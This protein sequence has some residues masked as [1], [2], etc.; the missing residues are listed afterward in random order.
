MISSDMKIFITGMV[1]IKLIENPGNG[2][3]NSTFLVL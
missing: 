3:E 1:K 2:E